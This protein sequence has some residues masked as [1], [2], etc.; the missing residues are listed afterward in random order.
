MLDVASREPHGAILPIDN[1]RTQDPARET[2]RDSV[3]ND[4]EWWSLNAPLPPR[5]LDERTHP[6]RRTYAAWRQIHQPWFLDGD[7]T[8]PQ[9]NPE[10][11]GRSR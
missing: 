6:V 1:Q 7:E 10:E 3:M 4:E 8:P 11:P 2:Q 5:V 9:A